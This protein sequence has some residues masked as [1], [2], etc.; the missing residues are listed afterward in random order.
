MKFNNDTLTKLAQD[1]FKQ[2]NFLING[3]PAENIEVL[4]VDRINRTFMVL[5]SGCRFLIH[6]EKTLSTPN[7]TSCAWA[8]NSNK[9]R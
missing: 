8:C 5:A 3:K 4:D 9:N 1:V 6:I 2:S 7:H